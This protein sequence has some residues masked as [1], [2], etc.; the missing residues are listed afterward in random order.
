MAI[1]KALYLLSQNTHFP[2]ATVPYP[3]MFHFQEGTQIECSQNY[4]SQDAL[5]LN[6]LLHG[7]IVAALRESSS[8]HWQ[9]W[10]LQFVVAHSPNDSS[11]ETK[12]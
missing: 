6:Y 11:A 5:L 1:S 9:D 10:P 4:I 2:F 12:K 7:K 3:W 8:F